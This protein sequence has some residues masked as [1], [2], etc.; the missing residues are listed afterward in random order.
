MKKMILT[1]MLIGMVGFAKAQWTYKKIDNGLDL[2]YK[3]A[4]T[5]TYR[6]AFLKMENVDGDIW[7]YIKADY[8]CNDE[9]NVDFSFFINGEWKRYNFNAPVSS[10]KDI[11][12]L[13]MGLNKEADF[14][15][16]FLSSTKVRLR[17]NYPSE[18]V[19]SSTIYEFN[20]LN[21]SKAYNF[22]R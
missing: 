19:C 15:T 13:E 20:M 4:F 2:P 12:W 10:S 16:D 6:N 9:V 3:V 21:S 11:V 8:F 7:L 18:E 17:V 5:E 1:A 14:L 22:M